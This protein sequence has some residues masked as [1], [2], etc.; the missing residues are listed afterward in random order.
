MKKTQLKV[1]NTHIIFFDETT[2]LICFSGIKPSLKK[3][4][5]KEKSWKVTWPETTFEVT[6]PSDA[7]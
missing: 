1:K 4:S 2:K 6:G 3:R 5:Q 7:K